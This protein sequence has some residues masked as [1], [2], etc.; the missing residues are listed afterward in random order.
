MHL[1]QVNSQKESQNDLSVILAKDLVIELWNAWIKR[2][3]SE[4]IP[5]AMKETVSK[6]T[7]MEIVVAMVD[8]DCQDRALMRKSMVVEWLIV[9]NPAGQMKN[10]EARPFIYEKAYRSSGS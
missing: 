9:W 2:M 8:K 6:E 5:P 7:A 10:L 1:G 4:I 3:I